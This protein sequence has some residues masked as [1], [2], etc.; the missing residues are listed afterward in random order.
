M[1]YNSCYLILLLLKVFNIFN[2]SHNVSLYNN[3]AFAI[4]FSTL[5]LLGEN[6][7]ENFPVWW[8]T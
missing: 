2:C 5:I 3:K 1:Y 7:L 4:A 8:E 6:I